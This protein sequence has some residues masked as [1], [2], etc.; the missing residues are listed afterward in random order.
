MTIQFVRWVYFHNR[1]KELLLLNSVEELEKFLIT[2]TTPFE[3]PSKNFK[4]GMKFIHF[5]EIL[6]WIRE[7]RKESG[8]VVSK[9]ES[10][11]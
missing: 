4:K 5:G 11:V 8:G 9:Q 2:H 7:K 1:E 3:D 10:L 6:N